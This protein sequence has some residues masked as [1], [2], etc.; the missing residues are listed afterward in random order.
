MSMQGSGPGSPLHAM[1]TS[2]CTPRPPPVQCLL[3]WGPSVRFSLPTP[4]AAFA[5]PS[6]FCF[7]SCCSAAVSAPFDLASAVS[8][9]LR[10]RF[11][12]SSPGVRGSAATA[13]C[14][15]R[16]SA[17][18]RSRQPLPA[19][20]NGLRS[21]GY[22]HARRAASPLCWLEVSSLATVTPLKPLLYPW[23]PWL[24]SCPILGV[25]SASVVMLAYRA[26]HG[27]MQNC[28]ALLGSEGHFIPSLLLLTWASA[29]E[30]RGQ[31]LVEEW[32]MDH[33]MT[34]AGSWTGRL[35]RFWRRLRKRPRV[36]ECTMTVE[37]VAAETPGPS[38]WPKPSLARRDLLPLRRHSSLGHRASHPRRSLRRFTTSTRLRLLRRALPPRAR[39]HQGQEWWHLRSGR[40][41][42]L[43]PM[44]AARHTWCKFRCLRR[45][46]H[47]PGC[48]SRAEMP[49]LCSDLGADWTA[50][51]WFTWVVLARPLPPAS[52]T[53]PVRKN[54]CS[55]PASG[56]VFCFFR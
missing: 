8:T 10:P 47:S 1:L 56:S 15:W 25:P 51:F 37:E 36:E 32:R 52:G 33:P 43:V 5:W 18:P 35:K 40:S 53:T 6:R 54:A 24:C 42:L 12:A 20:W 11:E 26:T 29:A 49:L 19:P 45:L 38:Q 7:S 28:S 48:L 31:R 14:F 22:A 41:L 27:W 9:S 50:S 17:L 21:P 4:L 34:F 55:G 23:R 13:L 44:E 46:C 16:P 2:V 30:R 3:S 39:Q